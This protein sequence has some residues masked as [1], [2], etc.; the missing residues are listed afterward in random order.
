[1]PYGQ[2]GLCTILL[3][4]GRVRLGTKV[5]YPP[6]VL[7]SLHPFHAHPAAH[8]ALTEI[9]HEPRIGREGKQ[10]VVMALGII[11]D[12]LGSEN[13]PVLKLRT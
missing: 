10:F 9:S 1:M 12:R 4:C 2:T 8:D 5:R 13:R 3:S 11:L 6:A 7:P